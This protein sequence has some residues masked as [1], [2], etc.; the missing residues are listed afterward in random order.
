MCQASAIGLYG[1]SKVWKSRLL[2]VGF[3]FRRKTASNDGENWVARV[4]LRERSAFSIGCGGSNSNNLPLALKHRLI[5]QNPLRRKNGQVKTR[6]F[7]QHQFS[8][9]PSHRVRLL[10]A[11]T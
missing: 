10:K 1:Y 2:Q 8:D 5:L 6:R 11:M 4:I 7:T 3:K 9:V